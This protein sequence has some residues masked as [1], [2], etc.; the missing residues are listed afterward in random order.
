MSLRKDW[1]SRQFV[2][3]D[4]DVRN[5]PISMKVEAGFATR[6]QARQGLSC[7]SDEKA[8]AV[9]IAPKEPAKNED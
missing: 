5:W 8:V 3:V 1:L 4:A 9:G 2:R 6:E 7:T